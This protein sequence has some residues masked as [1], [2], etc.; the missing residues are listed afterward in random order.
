M[1]RAVARAR[2][3]FMNLVSVTGHSSHTRGTFGT[4]AAT[5]PARRVGRPHSYGVAGRH[6]ATSGCRL[7]ANWFRTSSAP[8]K[9]WGEPRYALRTG[10]VRRRAEGKWNRA[11]TI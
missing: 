2:M 5:S 11:L 6:P 7:R 9:V 4:G 10:A 8:A 1:A 3:V